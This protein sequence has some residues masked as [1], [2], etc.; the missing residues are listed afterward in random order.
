[1]E[2]F[3]ADL[4]LVLPLGRR[5]CDE[6]MVVW[7][8]LL[9]GLRTVLICLLWSLFLLLIFFFICCSLSAVSALINA[10]ELVFAITSCAVIFAFLFLSVTVHFFFIIGMF[11]LSYALNSIYVF[12]I[13]GHGFKFLYNFMGITFSSVPLSILKFVFVSF[14]YSSVDHLFCCTVFTFFSI[15]RPCGG[16]HTH[17]GFCH[18][19]SAYEDFCFCFCTFLRN[20]H[21]CCIFRSFCYF[22][23]VMLSSMCSCLSS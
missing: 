15:W 19:C 17:G 11:V 22:C 10:F 7:L 14:M 1:M 4:L 18:V 5:L 8:F 13:S 2:R 12:V 6:C 23:Y 20:D 9:S 16:A 21:A 3:V